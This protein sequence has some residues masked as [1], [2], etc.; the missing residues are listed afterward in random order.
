[1]VRKRRNPTDIA[2][3]V[4]LF[5]FACVLLYPIYF[6]YV[7]S[8]KSPAIFYDPFAFPKE[9]YWGSFAIVFEKVKLLDGFFNTIVIMS[10]SLVSIVVICSMAGYAIARVKNRW[11]QAIYYLFLSGMIVPLQTTMVT[12]F[13]MGVSIQLIDTRTFM[14]LL[15]AAG[16]IP[17]A[18]FIYVGFMKSIPKEIEESAFIDGCGPMQSFA[19]IVLPLLLPATGTILITNVTAIYNDFMGPLLY[20]KSESK[21]TLMPQIV[22]FYAN[23]QSMDYGPVFALSALAVLPLILLFIFTQKYMIKGLIVGSL[24]G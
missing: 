4:G 24:K 10:F 21:M 7:G 14:V 9:L 13:K 3:E 16:A 17:I 18:T 22:Q 1:M 15:Y 19:R 2:I 8:F 6:L 11:F 5:L 12:I 20:L 23:K